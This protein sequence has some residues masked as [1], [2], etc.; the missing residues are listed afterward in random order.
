MAAKKKVKRLKGS[1]K[2]TGKALG[3][4]GAGQA[5]KSLRKQAQERQRVLKELLGN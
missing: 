4:G 3:T 2:V 1:P 5:A